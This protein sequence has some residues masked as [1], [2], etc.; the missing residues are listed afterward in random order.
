MAKYLSRDALDFMTCVAEIFIRELTLRSLFVAE[1]DHK[2]IQVS[3]IV[4]NAF[5]TV[6][7]N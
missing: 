2:V 7:E 1:T 6:L 4:N 3:F 5:L